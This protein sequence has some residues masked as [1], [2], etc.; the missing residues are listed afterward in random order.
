M[1]IPYAWKD[2]YLTVRSCK[3]I[4]FLTTPLPSII[5]MYVCILRSCIT[6]ENTVEN[7]GKYFNQQKIAREE[8]G[9]L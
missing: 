9:T 5:M 4:F 7:L 1:S 6:N 3:T 8:M 2:K